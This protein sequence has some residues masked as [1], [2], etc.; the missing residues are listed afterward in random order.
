LSFDESSD[1]QFVGCKLAMIITIPV[2]NISDHSCFALYSNSK[3]NDNKPSFGS[4]FYK[5]FSKHP[6]IP[7]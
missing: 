7:S 1:T 2:K 3:Y 6:D 4:S 5:L